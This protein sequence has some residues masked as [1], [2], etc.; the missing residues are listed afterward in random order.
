M[1]FIHFKNDLIEVKF[2]DENREDMTRSELN[3]KMRAY[4]VM[5]INH[6]LIWMIIGILIP[7]KYA[8][9]LVLSILW[10][11]YEQLLVNIPILYKLTKKYWFVP[12]YYW[13]EHISNQLLDIGINMAGY[14]VGSFLRMRV[15]GGSGGGHGGR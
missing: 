5:S 15:I 7:N 10:E 13:N 4:D 11:L 6:F 14:F 12:E 1:P 8:L 3:N 2:K 9:V